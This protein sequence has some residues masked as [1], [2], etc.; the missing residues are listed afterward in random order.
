MCI[1][2]CG[3]I[4]EAF[5]HNYKQDLNIALQRDRDAHFTGLNSA[6]ARRQGQE[7]EILICSQRQR[8]QAGP[9]EGSD[10][11]RVGLAPKSLLQEGYPSRFQNP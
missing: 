1:S 5:T 6:A 10:R 9:I 4:L 8:K 3:K 11:P 2:L 7:L